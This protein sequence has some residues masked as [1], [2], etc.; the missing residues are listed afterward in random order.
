MEKMLFIF[1]LTF[2]LTGL[3]CGS[4][5]VEFPES[6]SVKV[7]VLDPNQLTDAGSD[8]SR[9]ID[10]TP[11]DSGNSPDASNNVDAG[12]TD[13]SVPPFDAGQSED[14]GYVEPDSDSGY[15]SPDPC[16]SQPCE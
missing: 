5:L 8:S 13:S 14:S 9:D 3:A 1:A 4:R 2:T 16:V 7:V 6:D 11:F 12:Q 10:T 15:Y